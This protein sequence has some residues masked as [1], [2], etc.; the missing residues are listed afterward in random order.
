M[1]LNFKALANVTITEERFF[2][3]V[4]NYTERLLRLPRSEQHRIRLSQFKT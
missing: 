1:I 4:S 3:T 2:L